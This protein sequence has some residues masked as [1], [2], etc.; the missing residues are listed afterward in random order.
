MPWL[1]HRHNGR[2]HV[3]FRLGN[4]KLKKSLRTSDQRTAEARLHQV[5]ENIRLLEKGRIVVPED[6][7]IFE[8]LL[9]DGKIDGKLK[10]NTKLR[11]LKQFDDA[12]LASIPD[13][14]LEVET[15]KGMKIHLEHLYRVLNKSFL[16]ISLRLEDLQG[17]VEFRSQDKGNRGRNLS[18]ATIKKELATLRTLWNWARNAGHIVRVFPSRGLRYPK[19]IEKL[20]FQ[21]W[22][23]IKRKIETNQLTDDQQADLWECLFL[24]TSE[25]TELLSD[26]KETALHPCLY[27]TELSR[28]S[29]SFVWQTSRTKSRTRDPTSP[30]SIGLGYFVTQTKWYLMS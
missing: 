16:L 7:D 6:A 12:F 30:T 23:E 14:S 11:T 1:E 10:E 19:S 26:I 28:I 18:P 3:A 27:P 5:E 29:I 22:K 20:P 15:I 25:I 8:F 24:T 2:Y 13:N 21:T 17:Y 4:Q 9:S